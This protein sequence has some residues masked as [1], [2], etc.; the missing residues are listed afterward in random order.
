MIS[1][2]QDIASKR[3]GDEKRERKAILT[4]CG[5]PKDVACDVQVLPDDKSLDSAQLQ[6]LECIVDTEAVFARVLTDFVKVSLDEFLFL[7]ELDVC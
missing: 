1:S 7:N 4:T 2:A 5:I 6:G 3:H